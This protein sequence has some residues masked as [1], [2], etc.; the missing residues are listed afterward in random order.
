[1][2]GIIFSCTVYLALVD[3]P[4]LSEN[5]PGLSIDEAAIGYDAFTLLNTARDMHGTVLPVFFE[6]L[7][8]FKAPVFIY[9]SIAFIHFF[10]LTVTAVRV[11]SVAYAILSIILISLLS[12]YMFNRKIGVLSGLIL[13]TTPW[14]IHLSKIGFE[15]NSMNPWLLLSLLTTC[16]SFRHER[17]YPLAATSFLIFFFTYTG[18]R[19]YF[20]PIMILFICTYLSMVRKAFSSRFFWF[21]LISCTLV[22]AILIVPSVMDHTFFSRFLQSSAGKG[23][24]QEMLTSYQHHFKSLFLFTHGTSSFPGETGV[25]HSVI[26]MGVLNWFQLPFILFGLITLIKTKSFRRHAVFILGLLVIYPLGSIATS[27]VPQ[28]TRGIIGVLPFTILTAVGVWA[29]YHLLSSRWIKVTFVTLFATIVVTS[30]WFYLQL[31]QA[32]LFNA[33]G[34]N[35]FSFGVREAITYATSISSHYER[36]VFQEFHVHGI[37]LDFYDPNHLCRNCI[38]GSI[39]TDRNP[40]E[41]TLYILNASLY[42]ELLLELAQKS[43]PYKFNL[44][45]TILQPNFVPAFYLGTFSR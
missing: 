25:R 29:C 21:S 12:G 14:F 5:P 24:A 39:F 4:H 38:I 44:V 28:A 16:I 17:F 1:M 32:Y 42:D 18:A 34:E 7:G 11:T 43:L 6:S 9:S 35:G 33:S 40:T 30:T 22:L 45:E 31:S 8:D 19:A 2:L 10:G 26:G 37:Y 27:L 15:L 13:A 23:T 20:I 41:N 3:I 36:I